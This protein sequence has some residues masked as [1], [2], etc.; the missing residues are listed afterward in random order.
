MFKKNDPYTYSTY[1][2]LQTAGSTAIGLFSAEYQVTHDD[3]VQLGSGTVQ[4]GTENDGVRKYLLECTQRIKIYNSS[5]IDLRPE[6]DMSS[7]SDYPALI[8]TLVQISPQ[9]GLSMELVNFA[10]QT[11]NTQVQTSGTNGSSTGETNGSSTSST[12]GSSTSQTNSFGASV[13]SFGDLPTSSVSADH[14]KTTSQD[15]SFTS[16][17]ETSNS[18]GQDSSGSSSMSMKDWGA[19]CMVNPSIVSPSWTF[20]QEYPWDAIVC[21]KTNNT[22]N[23]DNPAQVQLVV[24]S[25]MTVR[26]YDGVSLSP[27]SHLSMFGVSFVMK[28]QWRITINNGTSDVVDLQHII[29][30]F[31]ASHSLSSGSNTVAVYLDSSPTLLALASPGSLSNALDLGVLGLAPI[32]MVTGP[33][34]IGFLPAKFSTMPIPAGSMGGPR[35]SRCSPPPTI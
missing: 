20:G 29:N 4:S 32:S 31:T 27:P 9:A 5:A 17:S 30:Y 16:G 26:L 3:D 22:S 35:P 7:Y 33:A 19:Y 25:S 12:V 8:N 10:P 21:R 2:Q 23:P 18:N 14:S 24:P 6:S 34:I 1:G 11:V 28:A 15:K 13:G